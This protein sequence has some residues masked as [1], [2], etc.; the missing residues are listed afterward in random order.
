MSEWN[1][2]DQQ[3]ILNWI[4]TPGFDERTL[5]ARH[6]LFLKN[7]RLKI[8]TPQENSQMIQWFS[9]K[10]FISCLWDCFMV[11]FVHLMHCC[12][13]LSFLKNMKKI[14]FKNMKK[15]V[16]RRSTE[17]YLLPSFR[18]MDHIIWHL[19][20]HPFKKCGK[21]NWDFPSHP[22]TFIINLL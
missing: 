13:P 14:S 20:C 15:L 6:N 7:R 8:E 10:D 12:L 4:K 21:Y 9:Y 3:K 5:R 18:K 22:G 17:L 16:S 2:Y 19:P 11:D 1:K